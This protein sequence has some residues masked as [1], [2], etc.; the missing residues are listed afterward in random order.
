MAKK[1]RFG[2]TSLD[3]VD[4]SGHRE[5]NEEDGKSKGLTPDQKRLHWEAYAKKTER[6]EEMFKRVFN[7]V[8]GE[9]AKEI[10]DY[11]EKHGQLPTLN[12]EETAKRFEAALRLTYEDAFQ[13]AV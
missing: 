2:D 1:N 4:L 10:S 13:G 3:F 9:Q 7:Y 8:F 11:Y 12:D 6:Q 5:P